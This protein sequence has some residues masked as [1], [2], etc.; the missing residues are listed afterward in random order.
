MTFFKTLI[1]PTPSAVAPEQVL[2]LTQKIMLGSAVCI[3]EGAIA[4]LGFL[5]PRGLDFY[6]GFLIMELVVWLALT[7][8]RSD[9]LGAAICDLYLLEVL[10]FAA[11][12]VCYTLA[13]KTHLFWYLTN[14]L[15]FLKL[16]RVYAK[17]GT[18][19][20]KYGWGTLGFMTYF[21]AKKF[22][23]QETIKH[24]KNVGL[25]LLVCI[26]FALMATLFHKQRSDFYREALPW[27]LAFTYI[28][29]NGPTLLKGIANLVTALF[30]SKK[31]EAEL[32]ATVTKLEKLNADFNGPIIAPPEQLAELKDNFQKIHPA[33]REVLLTMAKSLAEHHPVPDSEKK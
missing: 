5:L 6:I 4:S 33:Y 10:V 17:E 22:P 29:F 25:T 31:R 8:F 26:G 11:A 30:A 23:D 15:F 9:R 14:M 3:A 32:E 7:R 16:M 12:A 28:I 2:S 20:Q 27:G 24:R 21:Y 19:T 1:M 13:V 18:V